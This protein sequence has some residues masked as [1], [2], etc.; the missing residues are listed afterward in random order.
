LDDG[1]IGLS[2]LVFITGVIVG[3]KIVSD[4]GS[5][6]IEGKGLEDENEFEPIM[7][8]FFLNFIEFKLLLL[9]LFAEWSILFVGNVF[10]GFGFCLSINDL[11]MSWDEEEDFTRCCCCC[12]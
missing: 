4:V 6:F 11:D 12:C 9:L 3:V 10:V 8:G 5:C 7:F 2:F 1:V